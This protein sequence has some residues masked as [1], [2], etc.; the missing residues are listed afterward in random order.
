MD[1]H[2]PTLPLQGPAPLV[3]SAQNY[4]TDQFPLLRL[5]DLQDRHQHHYPVGSNPPQESQIRIGNSSGEG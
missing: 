5:P 1:L 4:G 2:P 3:P